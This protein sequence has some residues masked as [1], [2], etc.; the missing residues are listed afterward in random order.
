MEIIFTMVK[1]DP[2]EFMWLLED[3]EELVPVFVNQ[4]GK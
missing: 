1:D 3:M 2:T 4:D